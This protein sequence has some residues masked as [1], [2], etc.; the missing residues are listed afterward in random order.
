MLV[1]APLQDSVIQSRILPYNSIFHRDHC[2]CF[3]DFDAEAQFARDTP[4]LAPQ[5]Q[6]SLQLHDPRLVTKYKEVIHDQ[7]SYH[8]VFN[9]CSELE[10]A[11]DQN[12]WNDQH[13]VEYECLDALI[14]EVMLHAECTAGKKYIKRFDWPPT[15][16]ASVESVYYWHLLLK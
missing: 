15:L 14:T 3:L 8:K 11:A 16:I 12:T 4:P 10:K 6:R 2:P 9:C 7:L 5:C 1:S 13:T